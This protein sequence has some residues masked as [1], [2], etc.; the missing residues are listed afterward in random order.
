MNELPKP[1]DGPPP[2]PG[3]KKGGQ[4]TARKK[5]RFG[6]ELR[7]KSVDAFAVEVRKLGILGSAGLGIFGWSV[8][9]LASGP[10]AFAIALAIGFIL[11][12]VI[13]LAAVAIE[14]IRV[15]PVDGDSKDKGG[16]K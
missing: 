6:I 2:L 16:D 8:D 4:P 10:A 13:Q 5:K 1:Q 12:L 3:G 15:Y 11:W 7:Q 14:T 9:P